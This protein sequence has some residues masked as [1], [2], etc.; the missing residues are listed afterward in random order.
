MADN[1]KKITF[2]EDPKIRCENP[3][4]NAINM[5][6]HWYESNKEFIKIVSGIYNVL[7]DTS[8]EF[9]DSE[10]YR[11]DIVLTY[12]GEPKYI[13]PQECKHLNTH[14]KLLP[15]PTCFS[16]GLKITI[17]DDCN[18]TL[19]K[20]EL[21]IVDHDYVWTSNNDATCLNDGTETGVCKWDNNTITRIIPGSALG[22][23]YPDEWTIG[24]PASC[25]SVG[26]KYKLCRRCQNK[27]TEVIPALSHNWVSNNNGTHTCSTEGG[28]GKTES[29][30]PTTP[31]VPCDKCGYVTNPLKILTESLPTD[32][33]NN[34]AYPNTALSANI[35]SGVIWSISEGNLPDGLSLSS[36]GVLNG[37]PSSSG[38]Y[39]FTVKAEYNNQVDTKSFTIVIKNA[40]CEVRF[41]SNWDGDT[42][43]ESMT[44]NYGAAIGTL[45]NRTRENYDFL[46]W[47]TTATGGTQINSTYEVFSDIILYAHWTKQMCT[48]T[49]DSNEGICSESIRNVGKGEAIGSL[50]TPTRDGYIFGGWYTAL[51][52]G[53]QVD[54]NYSINSNVTL[55]A[56]WAEEGTSEDIDVIFGDATTQ[57]NVSINGDRTN[58]NNNP[59]TLYGRIA[60]GRYGRIADG[61][62]G[63]HNLTFQTGFTSDD[64]T[65][66]ITALNKKV[67]LYLKVTNNGESG[68]FDIGFD[69]DS[70]IVGDNDDNVLITRIE[71]GVRL[72]ANTK[73]SVTVPYENTAWVGK[74]NERTAHRYVDY[75]IGRKTNNIDTGY[76][77]TMKNIHINA[78]SYTILEVTFEIP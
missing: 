67:I 60:D 57:F 39:T 36:D 28:C 68:E 45:P 71:N 22:H 48:I 17:C 35:T 78:N 61:R 10:E 53:L 62:F 38:S 27:I 31:G 70:Y 59:Y 63:R 52:G 64:M 1:V 55:Y 41:N 46:G 21:D 50:P 69:C 37:N 40:T 33:Y 23:D 34:T 73:L 18:I 7:E 6:R 13:N 30:Y 56:R 51:T 72:G 24:T 16:K 2:Y 29:C 5:A 76:C 14:S 65:N 19:N 26:E 54:E 11:K 43:I 3:F 77:L 47:F 9:K 20:E 12:T 58:Y 25:G 8:E 75:E 66:N 44:V 42:S 32:V 49:F 4:Y 74:Y 15:E